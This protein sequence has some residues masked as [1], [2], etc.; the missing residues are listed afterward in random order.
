MWEIIPMASLQ[1][2]RNVGSLCLTH[3]LISIM[4]PSLFYKSMSSMSLLCFKMSS[5]DPFIVWSSFYLRRCWRTSTCLSMLSQNPSPSQQRSPERGPQVVPQTRAC[6]A[7][8]LGRPSMRSIFLLQ[9]LRVL[10]SLKPLTRPVVNRVGRTMVVS[11]VN[12]KAASGPPCS[13]EKWW[14]TPHDQFWLLLMDR[15]CFTIWEV[16]CFKDL[17]LAIK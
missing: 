2:P 16:F 11:T 12:R 13:T 5:S 8:I 1:E 14:I 15:I 7:R 6:L 3:K 4:V 17:V 9:V 10:V